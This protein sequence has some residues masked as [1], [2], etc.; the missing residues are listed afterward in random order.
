MKIG[1]IFVIALIIS[2]VCFGYALEIEGLITDTMHAYHFNDN[3]VPKCANEH[4]G[5]NGV[6]ITFDYEKGSFAVFWI[7]MTNSYGNPGWVFGIEPAKAEFRTDFFKISAAV[8]FMEI[9]GYKN[10]DGEDTVFYLETIP[11]FQ[12]GFNVAFWTKYKVFVNYN[13]LILPIPPIKIDWYSLDYR[14]EF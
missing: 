5:G 14:I 11:K 12:I 8:W 13:V 7:W 9:H 6:K 1:L 4:N 2:S 10:T 3:C